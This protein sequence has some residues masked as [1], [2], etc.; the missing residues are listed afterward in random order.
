LLVGLLLV[1]GLA[2]MVPWRWGVFM[3]LIAVV[4]V[5]AI[6]L[7]VLRPLVRGDFVEKKTGTAT[8]TARVVNTGLLPL[9]FEPKGQPGVHVAPGHWVDLKFP[10]TDKNQYFDIKARVDLSLLGWLILGFLCAL[11]LLLAIGVSIR[12]WRKEKNGTLVIPAPADALEVAA[13]TGNISTL[14][15]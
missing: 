6:P 15:W 8:I 7:I 9:K 14:G 3:P 4:I 13:P 2:A 5:V 12:E 10:R 1:I 11:P